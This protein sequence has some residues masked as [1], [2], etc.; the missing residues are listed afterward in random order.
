MNHLSLCV[1]YVFLLS[2]EQFVNND[3]KNSY[4]RINSDFSQQ[5]WQVEMVGLTKCLMPL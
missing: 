5:H 3:K 2:K 4:I 1:I